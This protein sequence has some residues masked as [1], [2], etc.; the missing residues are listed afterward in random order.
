MRLLRLAA[1]AI[2]ALAAAPASASAALTASDVR[3]GAQPAFVRVVVDMTGGVA[4]FNEVDATDPRVADGSARID[5]SHPA[6]VVTPRDRAAQGVRARLSL[7]TA[8]RARVQL[9]A[10]AGRFKYVRVS[11]LHGP[12]RVVIDLYRS[13]PPSPPAEIR[14]GVRSCLTLTSIQ[15]TGHVFRVRGTERNLFE[16]S[17]VIRVRDVRGRVVGRRIVT[18]RGP[19]SQTVSYSGVGSRQAGTVEAVADSAKDGSLACIVQRRVTLA[20]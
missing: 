3:I 2:A 13:A 11:V 20:P 8:N 7:A 1:L 18:A 15:R 12:E 19:W 9:T 4:A 14:T 6:I 17:F 16:G 5:I 10:A